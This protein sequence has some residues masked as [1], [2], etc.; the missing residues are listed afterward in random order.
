MRHAEIGA[1][2]D[3]L[4]AHLGAGHADGIIDAVADRVI[5]LDCGAHIGADAAEEQEIDRRF[6]D[7]VHDLAA[8]SFSPWQSERACACGR[9]RDLLQRSRETPPPVEISARS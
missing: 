6:E 3:H 1:F 7:R 8:G 5:T 9:E 4:G 2:A